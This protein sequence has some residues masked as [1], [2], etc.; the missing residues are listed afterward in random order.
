[1]PPTPHIPI[2]TH[3]PLSTLLV[4]HS[5]IKIYFISFVVVPPPPPPPL[6]IV[7]LLY[8][9]RPYPFHRTPVPN[10]PHLPALRFE[11]GQDDGKRKSTQSEKS[12]LLGPGTHTHTHTITPPTPTPL[13]SSTTTTTTQC[14]KTPLSLSFAGLSA[15][16]LHSSP[17]TNLPLP[18]ISLLAFACAP[19]AHTHT[20]L[21]F[22]T[23]VLS[24]FAAHYQQQ[25]VLCSL[26]SAGNPYPSIPFWP[27]WARDTGFASH[28]Q[29]AMP[30]PSR[31]ART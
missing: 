9:R 12:S 19:Y 3:T 13:P 8:R 17:T 31:K 24:Y 15:T 28:V 16:Q 20:H 29:Q 14:G 6:F 2:H 18:S 5:H 1:M 10:T 23:F 30:Q 27:L 21:L 22:C 11:E 4:L 26:P 7:P 25:A